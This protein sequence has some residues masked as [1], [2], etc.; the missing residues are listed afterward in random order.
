MARRADKEAQVGD[1]G[2]ELGRRHEPFCIRA[3]A[4]QL[5]REEH[6]DVARGRRVKEGLMPPL[7]G[8]VAALGHTHEAVQAHGVRAHGG[9]KVQ[10]AL[11]YGRVLG[12]VRRLLLIIECVVEA[13]WRRR[14][15]DGTELVRCR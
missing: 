8:C 7:I 4:E 11:E 15:V 1:G 6:A 5:V 10:I 12:V 9:Y 13:P 2:R 14:I 3:A